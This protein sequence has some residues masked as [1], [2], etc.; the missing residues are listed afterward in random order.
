MD[1]AVAIYSGGMD[2]TALAYMLQ[3]LYGELYLI[4]FDYGQRHRKELTCAKAIAEGLT[5]KETGAYVQHDVV[6]LKAVTQFLKGS[7]LTDD[8]EVPEGHYGEDNMRLTVVPNRNMMMLS[9]ATAIAVARGSVA[10]YT[11]VHAGD[12][13]V[14]PDC[15]PEFMHHVNAA[16]QAGNEGFAV[17]GFRIEA[18]FVHMEKSEIAKVGQK[19]GVPWEKTWSCYKGGSIH[20][21]KCGT[22]VERQEA[23]FV[24]GVP[25]PT[26]YEDPN[27]WKFV[28]KIEGVK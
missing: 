27:Y 8:V 5:D 1:S 13:F 20:C 3:E 16:A 22:C 4:S 19:H 25:D 23:F 7:S 21:G 6:N 9:V 2:S 12:H 10:V 14:Y 26:K 28:T 24:A 17:R 11:G 18:P 15:R